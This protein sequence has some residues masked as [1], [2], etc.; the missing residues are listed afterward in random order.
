MSYDPL[1]YPAKKRAVNGRWPYLPE[2][3]ERESNW[4][5]QSRTGRIE[6]RGAVLQTEPGREAYVLAA[7]EFDTFV[8][9]NPVPDPTLWEL[10][11]PDG[12]RLRADARLGLAR[13]AVQTG[14][15]TLRV[16]YAEKPGVDRPDMATALLAFGWPEPPV[17]ELN[18]RRP[19]PLRTI[20]IDGKTAHLIPLTDGA[21]EGVER[22]FRRFDGKR[23][24]TR[25][26]H[27]LDWHVVG[28]FS[29]DFDQPQGPQVEGVNLAAV[30][31]G[32]DGA[33]VDWRRT[34]DEEEPSLGLGTVDLEPIF[35]PGRQASAYAY[36]RILSD[37]EREV[38]LFFGSETNATIWINGER[39][40]SRPP[41][42]RSCYPDQDRLSIRLRQGVNDV[43]LRLGRNW[44]GWEFSFRLADEHGLPL[45]AGVE[46]LTE[47]GAVPAGQAP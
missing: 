2:G 30:Y 42:F 11:L 33:E 36:T 17:L 23:T 32:L 25:G 14:E 27:L 16:D 44:E 29:P 20:E 9:Y 40:F 6:K 37:A 38:T 8:A 39:V 4:A 13:V 21:R 34:V 41:F 31:T 43:L 24:A 45:P 7:P 15:N 12:R 35:Q 26:T 5:I 18:G 1:A 28:P 3:V 47:D 10:T 46:Y 19:R 22:R